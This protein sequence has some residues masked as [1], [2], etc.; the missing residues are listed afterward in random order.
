MTSDE[1]ALDNSAQL[2]P[3]VPI[4]IGGMSALG[5]AEREA[6]NEVLLER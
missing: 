5:R 4:V 1:V 3:G 2:A 6:G